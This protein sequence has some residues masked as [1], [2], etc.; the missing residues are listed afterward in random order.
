MASRL[1]KPDRSGRPVFSRSDDKH[2][3]DELPW[4]YA[5]AEEL[6]EAVERLAMALQAAQEPSS[7][8]R[9]VARSLR[10]DCHRAAVVLT[11]NAGVATLAKRLWERG[12]SQVAGWIKLVDKARTLDKSL[13]T[14]VGVDPTKLPRVKPDFDICYWQG[15]HTEPQ[16]I[17]F[18]LAAKLY[19]ADTLERLYKDGFRLRCMAAHPSNA[20]VMLEDASRLIRLV[21]RHL[22]DIEP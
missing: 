1:F 3:L 6:A 2:V 18:G 14:R 19:S 12:G 22:L 15:R 20:T 17:F 8:L 4:S 9:E 7:L 21:S 10:A 16:I 5:T 13:G 11:W